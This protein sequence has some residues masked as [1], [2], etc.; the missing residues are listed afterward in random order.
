MFRIADSSCATRENLPV[1]LNEL[2]TITKGDCE[3]SLVNSALSCLAKLIDGDWMSLIG[4][5]PTVP[6]RP[7]C[8]RQLGWATTEVSVWVGVA[9][10]IE[11]RKLMP[12]VWWVNS[13]STLKSRST[14]LAHQ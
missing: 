10:G 14:P 8:T 6:P 12:L 1:I 9:A 11:L 3:P 2:R 7:I 4:F 13:C 5:V